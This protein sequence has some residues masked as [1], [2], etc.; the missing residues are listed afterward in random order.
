MNTFEKIS[1]GIMPVDRGIGDAMQAYIDE[2]AK[3]LGSLGYLEKMAVRVSRIT[4][5]LDNRINKKAMIVMCSD[6]GIYEEGVASSP[7]Y[8]TRT[9]A[10][11]MVVGKAAIG[12]L[13]KADNIDLQVIDIGIN[14]DSLTDFGIIDKKIGKGTFNISR[15]PAMTEDEAIRSIEV[16]I[17]AAKLA[18]ERGADIIGTGEMGIGNTSTS[19]AVLMT[20]L[21]CTADE[22]VGKG[23]GLTPEAFEHKKV[24]IKRVLEV[25]RPDSDDPL[26]ILTKVGGF[27]IGGLVGVFLGGAY[28]RKPVVVDGL[29]SAVA[30]LLACE[31]NPFVRDY[32]FPSHGS[33]EPG[34]PLAIKALGLRSPLQFHMRL[35][36][37]VGCPLLFK[38]MDSALLL[39]KEMNTLDKVD[40]NKE[41]M[42]DIRKN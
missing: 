7:Q 29:I 5:K 39:M 13:C 36:E 16:G 34:F 9:Q 24:V 25:N 1:Q 26:D 8:V 35:G 18:V 23:G 3:P 41:H 30:A 21:N 40:L 28:L 12:V 38:M 37:G 11:N 2:L 6:N 33:T 27:D 10:V 32:L 17:D 22:C 4:G 31:I 19:S 20:L 42:V 14:S 15:G